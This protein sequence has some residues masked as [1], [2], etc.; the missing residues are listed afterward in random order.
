[1]AIQ[2]AD[3]DFPSPLLSLQAG[4]QHAG[5]WVNRLRDG[6][7]CSSPFVR[8]SVSDF[9]KPLISIQRVVEENKSLCGLF[10]L[11]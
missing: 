5:L 8:R 6:K 11:I 7:T 9:A 3:T 4:F 2:C 10:L 1:M